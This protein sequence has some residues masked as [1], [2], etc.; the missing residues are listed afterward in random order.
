MDLQEF[1]KQFGND[2]TTSFQYN[3]ENFNLLFS[4]YENGNWC[5]NLV[6]DQQPIGEI[7]DD[8]SLANE[9]T[10]P[11][12]ALLADDFIALS[13]EKQDYL[14]LLA[15]ANVIIKHPFFMEKVENYSKG[16]PITKDAYQLHP[17]FMTYIK[18]QVH[19]NLKG[20]RTP[21]SLGF[22][23]NKPSE[24][25]DRI[26]FDR[27][28]QL[29][30]NP[31]LA[32]NSAET[33]DNG[34]HG[35]DDISPALKVKATNILEDLAYLDQ[36]GNSISAGLRVKKYAVNGAFY[37]E[38]NDKETQTQQIIISDHGIVKQLGKQ[39]KVNLPINDEEL[40]GAQISKNWLLTSGLFDSVDTDNMIANLSIIGQAVLKMKVGE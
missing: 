1:S 39:V 23:I 29:R 10:V 20:K 13:S 12:K 33:T 8:L 40:V 22:V 24:G 15:N 31:D 32:M 17:D 21:S 38:L 16:R 36:D 28:R 26:I 5:L 7:S 27:D 2:T 6:S 11:T 9:L 18:K 37:L 30:D 35:E 25:L 4:R 3:N 19:I 34:K 14:R